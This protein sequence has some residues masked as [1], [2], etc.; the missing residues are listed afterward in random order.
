MEDLFSRMAMLMCEDAARTPISCRYHKSRELYNLS[1]EAWLHPHFPA[2][3]CRDLVRSERRTARCTRYDTPV[4]SR[5]FSPGPMNG[6][7]RVGYTQSTVIHAY[8][9]LILLPYHQLARSDQD[10]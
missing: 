4:F 5:P 2:V 9:D 8:K 3:Q 7:V 1:T 10:L 6:G